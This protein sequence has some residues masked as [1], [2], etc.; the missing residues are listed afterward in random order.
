MIYYSKWF[1][2]FQQKPEIKKKRDGRK[3]VP[4]GDKNLRF[5]P[6]VRTNK[7]KPPAINGGKN[8]VDLKW[9]CGK[10]VTMRQRV[11]AKPC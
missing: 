4:H 8:F 9:F 5:R 6:L 1:E 11:R 10:A 3:G 7:K 2:H